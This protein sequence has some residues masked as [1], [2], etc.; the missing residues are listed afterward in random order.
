MTRRS[1]TS[2]ATFSVTRSLGRASRLRRFQKPKNRLLLSAVNHFS[3]FTI[4]MAM[5]NSK[6]WLRLTIALRSLRMYRHGHA[7]NVERAKPNKSLD[8]SGGSLFLIK[9]GAAKVA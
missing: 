1:L 9:H 4:R 3:R 6:R 7:G 2:M 5:A 8:R